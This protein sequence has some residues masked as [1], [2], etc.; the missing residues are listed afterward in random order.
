MKHRILQRAVECLRCTNGTRVL[1]NKVPW[2]YRMVKNR[3]SRAINLKGFELP[4]LSSF[5][6]KNHAAVIYEGIT[7]RYKTRRTTQEQFATTV[8]EI[9][10]SR[11]DRKP[12][13][14]R[15]WAKRQ[16]D[17]SKNKE[18]CLTGVY[19]GEDYYLTVDDVEIEKEDEWGSLSWRWKRNAT[20]RLSKP[21]I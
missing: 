20:S 17:L 1:G 4:L 18:K 11:N 21:L 12:E 2:S 19:I 6:N 15:R 13:K 16:S 8:S 3:R 7:T 10:Q 9:I 14:C 5:K